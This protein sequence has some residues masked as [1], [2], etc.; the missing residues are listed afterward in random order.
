MGWLSRLGLSKVGAAM[1]N[2]V[3]S[4][5]EGVFAAISQAGE[6]LSTSDDER[7]KWAEIMQKVQQEP[8]VMQAMITA[9]STTSGSSFIASVRSTVMYIMAF[10]VLYGVVIRDVLVL[11]L[12]IKPED[13]PPVQVESALILHYLGT[14][15]GVSG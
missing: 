1:D 3:A 11:T 5:A 8:Q 6:R 2:P 14:L 13:V 4:A 12:G 15:L 10:S 7:A 9:M